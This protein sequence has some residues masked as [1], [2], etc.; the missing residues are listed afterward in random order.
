[1]TPAI[2]VGLFIAFVVPFL[3]Y[4]VGRLIFGAAL[5]DARIVSGVA[6]H[7]ATLAGLIAVIVFWERLPLTSIGLRPVRCTAWRSIT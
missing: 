2:S 7:W 1:L 3:G 6:V 4:A 5:S